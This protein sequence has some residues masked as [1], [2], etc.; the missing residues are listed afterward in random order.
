MFH[1][2]NVKNEVI[3]PIAKHGKMNAITNRNSFGDF[4][5]LSDG[6]ILQESILVSI[7]NFPQSPLQV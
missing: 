1:P 6:R 5:V 3:V 7:P 4:P 2:I